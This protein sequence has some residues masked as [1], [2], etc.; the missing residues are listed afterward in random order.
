MI[1]AIALIS[2]ATLTNFK[3]DAKLHSHGADSG[4]FSKHMTEDSPQIMFILNKDPRMTKW[5]PS[6]WWSYNHASVQKG[7]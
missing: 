4:S 2:A 5:S 3:G 1:I 6:L 7:C